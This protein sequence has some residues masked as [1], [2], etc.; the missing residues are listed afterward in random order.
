MNTSFVSIGIDVSKNHLDVHI[1]PL[2]KAA[3]FENN[4][5]GIQSLVASMVEYTPDCILL[6]PSGGYER[7]AFSALQNAGLPVAMINARQIRDFARAKGILAKTD[8]IDACVLADYAATFKP[9]TSPRVEQKIAT[10]S[11]Y[12]RRRKQL[13]DF[14]NAEKA[15]LETLL[16]TVVIESINAH[17]EMLKD[18]ITALDAKISCFI[19]EDQTLCHKQEIITSCKGIGSVTAATLLA[20]MPE[21]GT[22]QNNKITALAGLAPFNKDSGAMRGQ[23]HITG[24]RTLP[25]NALYMATLSAI[26]FNPDIKSFYDRLRKL[27]KKPKV[28][29][30]AAMRKLLLTLNSI[31]KNNRKWQE[32]LIA[33]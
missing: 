31:L 2:G 9:K 12:V 28:A 17:Q 19:D 11:L 30:V 25:R 6:E 29:L 33:S 15:H 8:A 32:K 27:G 22:L 5:M 26:R 16:D 7:G 14:L 3:R 18:A 1:L 4:S 24:G 20:E 23:R 10:L 21:L 13:I